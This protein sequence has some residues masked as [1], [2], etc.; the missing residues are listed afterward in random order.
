MMRAAGGAPSYP[1]MSI[2]GGQ[3]VGGITVVPSDSDAVAD[4]MI[5]LDAS[6]VAAD[7]TLPVAISTG[8]HATLDMAG[9][10]T[11]TFSVWQKNARALKCER[12]F[13]FEVLRNDSVVVI[14][15]VT[16]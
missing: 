1:E 10:G 5:L 16:A 8:D 9:T 11:P 2:G 6:S 3:I 7:A 15:G 4:E 14:T 13:A 12:R